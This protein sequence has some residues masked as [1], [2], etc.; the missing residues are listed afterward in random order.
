MANWYTRGAFEIGSGGTVWTTSSMRVALVTSTY[1]FSKAHNL[2]NQITNEVTGGGYARATIASPTTS[3]NDASTR[4]EYDATDTAFTNITGTNVN[5]AI[6]LRTTGSDSTSPLIWYVD[7][8][9]QS[10]AA[11]DLT[12]QWS[13]S[14]IAHLTN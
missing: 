2:A 10:P 13:S 7:F 8:T 1:T 11:A 4:V 6:I 3:E 9:A 14:G 12:L 5:A